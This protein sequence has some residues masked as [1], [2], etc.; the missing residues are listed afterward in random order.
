M[1]VQRIDGG[2]GFDTLTIF[3]SGILSD[4]TTLPD[5]RLVGIEQI[6]LG[7]S[8]N[9]LVLNQREVLNISSTSN[10]LTV[11]GESNAR[12]YFESGWTRQADDTGF[13]VY[14]KGAATLRV[15]VGVP[16]LV[17]VIEL[18]DLG[19]AG[20]TVNGEAADDFSG[21]S[22][23]DAGDVNGDGFD[24]FIIGALLADAGTPARGDAGK[25]YVVFGGPSLAAMIELAT[26]GQSG[27]PAGFTILGQADGDL[28]G[29]S[30]SSAG[31]STATAS[32][33]SS[34]GLM[35]RTRHT[36]SRQRR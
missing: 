34:S 3:N 26:L 8:S 15:S 25:T 5:N 18:G 13:Q 12:V 16:V 9:T 11:L 32:T 17:N 7:A 22:V 31:T 1:G 28:S 29:R 36:G 24:D 10:T 19:S 6:D 14:T 2:T 21:T 30:V 4:L 27:Q 23:S 33:I 20:I 35:G